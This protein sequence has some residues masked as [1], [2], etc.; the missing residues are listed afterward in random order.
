MLYRAA[1][2]LVQIAAHRILDE[3]LHDSMISHNPL[4]YG[5][6]LILQRDA[7]SRLVRNV[8]LACKFLQHLHC[9]G[10]CDGDFI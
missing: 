7:D 5:S 10:L 4:P 1:N 6:A 9:T 8:A 2:L 3:S